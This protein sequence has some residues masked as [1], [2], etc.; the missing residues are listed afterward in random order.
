VRGRERKIERGVERE[1]IVGEIVAWGMGE[2]EGWGRRE[3]ECMRGWEGERARQI[4]WVETK[5][6]EGGGE[7]KTKR[8]GRDRVWE[9]WKGERERD[10]ERKGRR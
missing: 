2:G 9:G 3:R 1:V 10:S 5:R 6:E 7:R 8:R 4:G